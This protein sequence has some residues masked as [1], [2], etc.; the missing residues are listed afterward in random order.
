MVGAFGE[1]QVMDWGVAKALAGGRS[2]PGVGDRVPAGGPADADRPAAETG[3]G[4]VLGTPAYMP[5]EQA[6]GETDRVDERADVFALGAILCEILTGRPPYTGRTVAEVMR[7]ACRG[8]LAEAF[9]RLDGCG[10]D[11]G[12]GALA[13]GWPGAEGG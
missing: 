10:A 7:L 5:P 3:A 13:K 4:A 11:E 12:L 2:Q 8:D 9:A 1:V 6:L